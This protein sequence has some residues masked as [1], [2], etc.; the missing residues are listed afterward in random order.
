MGKIAKEVTATGT[1]D[2]VSIELNGPYWLTRNKTGGVLADNIEVWLVKP[3]LHRFE[4]GDIMWLAN[5][6]DVD[7]RD[8]YFGEWTV[9]KCLKECYV[10]P[11][12]E[13]ECLKVG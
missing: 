12:T 7:S 5:Y 4:D 9:A 1:G 2:S 13:R 8:T 10:Y 6:N 11:E 3:D